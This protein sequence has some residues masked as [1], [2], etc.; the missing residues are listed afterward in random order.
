M[1]PTDKSFPDSAELSRNPA[2]RQ[3]LELLQSGGT[4]VDQVMKKAAAGDPSQAI[5]L[6]KTLMADPKARA[7]LQE[8]G[9]S[10]GRNGK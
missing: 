7:L 5:R 3:L 9:G 4:D 2:A 10:Y 8:L 1:H 6:L